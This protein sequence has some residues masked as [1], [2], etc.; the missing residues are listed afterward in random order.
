MKYLAKLSDW[1]KL[2]QGEEIGG[3]ADVTSLVAGVSPFLEAFG[4]A[5]TNMNDN[6]S[7]FGKFTKIWLDDGK[8]IGA[9]LEHYLLEKARIVGQ[10]RNERNY[11]VFYF[12][13]RGS[14]PEEK[15]M[16][17]DNGKTKCDDY[18]KLWE[19]A[20]KHGKKDPKLGDV[21]LLGHGH[22]AEY[23]VEHMNNPLAK[24][25]DDT[26][27]RAALLHAHV[28][29]K[30]QQDMWRIVA[31]VLRITAME[32]QDGASEEKGDV[33]D[34]DECSRIAKLLGFQDEGDMGFE[35]LLCCEIRVISKKEIRCDQTKKQCK[36]NANALAKEIYGHL[37]AWLIDTVCN[38]VLCPSGSKDAFVG[39]LD[40]FGFENFV[41]TGGSNSIEQLCINFANEKLQYLFNK[42]V[43]DDEKKMYVFCSSVLITH[44]LQSTRTQVRK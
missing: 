13:L 28:E 22:G 43:F 6:S 23:D 44:L 2:E 11:H 33:K 35:A 18:P 1:R 3:D 36:D 20:L 38:E 9:E 31:G 40:I 14:T 16:Y 8:I 4:N 37:F 12:L 27:L 26:G 34:K 7:R 5:K 39:L 25:P 32:F 42:H 30:T 24:D 41:P 17:F 29:E 21:T 10:G 19:G 15:K